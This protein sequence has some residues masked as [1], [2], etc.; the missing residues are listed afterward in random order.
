MKYIAPGSSRINIEDIQRT[1]W[2]GSPQEE[3]ANEGVADN[4]SPDWT[5]GKESSTDLSLSENSIVI[6]NKSKRKVPKLV[7]RR[8]VRQHWVA[9][10]KPDIVH[11]PK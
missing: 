11:V 7:I 1:G 4:F 6:R 2:E 5:A 8:G 10:E 3:Y 9:V